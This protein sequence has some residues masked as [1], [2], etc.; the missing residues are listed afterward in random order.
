MHAV[1]VPTD[2]APSSAEVAS[3][4]R[5]L[6]AAVEAEDRRAALDGVRDLWLA[7]SNLK[8]APAAVATRGKEALSEFARARRI[9]TRKE[10]AIMEQAVNAALSLVLRT[11]V[12]PYQFGAR[13]PHLRLPEFATTKNIRPD[14]ICLEAIGP[15]VLRSRRYPGWS[16]SVP[17]MPKGAV[18]E[19][20]THL[21]TDGTAD[22]KLPN[23]FYKYERVWPDTGMGVLVVLTCR[24][25]AYMHKAGWFGRCADAATCEC[26]RI[27]AYVFQWRARDLRTFER[28]SSIYLVPATALGRRGG[29]LK[30]KTQQRTNQT[31]QIAL[32]R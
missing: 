7:M 16:L 4:L 12:V 20:K 22:E 27:P 28:R 31:N 9:R 15:F 21:W 32:T 25:E 17:A 18:V 19:T 13:S 29:R 24:A 11:Q 10:S 26:G 30:Q 3:V 6:V 8:T 1:P 5:E 14:G 23:T 2:A